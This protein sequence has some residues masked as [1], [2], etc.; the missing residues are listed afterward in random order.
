MVIEEI[1]FDFFHKTYHAYAHSEKRPEIGF[2]VGQFNR[3]KEIN[4]GYHLE[5]WRYQA[6]NELK[7]M[8]EEIYLSEKMDPDQLKYDVT[9]SDFHFRGEAP[10]RDIP[11]YKEAALIDVGISMRDS[12]ITD[13]NKMDEFKKASRL[14]SYIKEKGIKAKAIH[15]SYKNKY[16]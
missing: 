3:T 15:I 2:Y 11:D 5:I 4:D 12:G 7:P 9:I 16:I 6:K 1:S 10:N 14:I 13:T 8:I